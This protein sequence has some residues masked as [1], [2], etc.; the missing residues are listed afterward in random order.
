MRITIRNIDGSELARWTT[1]SKDKYG[2]TPDIGRP[3]FNLLPNTD[4]RC[5]YQIEFDNAS[6]S[7]SMPLATGVPLNLAID[8]AIHVYNTE[9]DPLVTY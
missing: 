7:Q 3:S 4:E 2:D 9:H 1:W 6:K 5:P 8:L